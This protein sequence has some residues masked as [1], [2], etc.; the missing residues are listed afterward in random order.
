[1]DINYVI[2][3]LLFVLVVWFVYKRVA[4]VKNLRNLTE[5]QLREKLRITG[6][7]ALIDVRETNE[8]NSGHIHG[9]INIPLSKLKRSLKEIPT[10]KELILYCQSGMRSKQAARMLQ[11]QKYKGISHL[12]GGIASWSGRKNRGNG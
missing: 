12:S 3:I 7:N 11:K 8:F 9:A 6:N 10:D 4:P 1:M 2:N 5:E